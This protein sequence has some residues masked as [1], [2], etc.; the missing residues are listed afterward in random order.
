MLVQR[1]LYKDVKVCP[2]CKGYG[3]LNPKDPSYEFEFCEECE[4]FGT[5]IDEEKGRVVFGLPLFTDFP[6]RK[7]LRL[8]RIVGILVALV[9]ILISLVVIF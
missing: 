7:R 5:Y 3:V 4:G 1:D 6:T 9:I 8:I 2:V